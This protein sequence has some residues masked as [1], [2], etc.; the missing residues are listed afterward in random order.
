[1]PYTLHDVRASFSGAKAA[2]ERHDLMFRFFA[3][4]LSFPIAWVALQ[5]GFTPNHVT[6]VSLF[7]NLAGLGM[8]ASGYRNTVAWGIGLLLVSLVLD[9]AD[10]NMARTAKHFSP[11]GEWLEGVGAYILQG[12][13]HVAGGVGAWLALMRGLPISRWPLDPAWGGVLVAGGAVAAGSITLTMLIATK[14]NTVFPAVDRNKVVA[15]AGGGLYGALFTLGRNLSF[16]SGLV[17]PL[18]L[19]AV[20]AGRYE[21]LVGGFAVLNTGMLL[22]VFGRCVGLALRQ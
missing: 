22:T 20:L 12:A 1:M 13:F 15:R 5:I 17:L 6:V 19:V 9:A 2:Q 7:L 11:M 21:L 10:G 8:M 4:P 3:R 16:A 14:F 18:S